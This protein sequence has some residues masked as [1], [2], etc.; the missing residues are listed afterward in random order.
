MFLKNNHADH[1]TERIKSIT[2][3]PNLDSDRQK[4]SNYEP[5]R[6]RMQRSV[7]GNEERSTNFTWQAFH[8][9]QAVS[10]GLKL[11]YNLSGYPMEK[12]LKKKKASPAA[13]TRSKRRFRP[14]SGQARKARQS[15]SRLIIQSCNYTNDCSGRTIINDLAMNSY[16]VSAQITAD[17]ASDFSSKRE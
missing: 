11:L 13:E 9:H 16:S 8:F 7:T 1:N 3:R 6:R 2:R 10:I 4:R 17:F 12:T 5:V 15:V 14:A